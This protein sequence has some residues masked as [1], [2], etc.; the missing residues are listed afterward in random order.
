LT[1][2]L[3]R[4]IAT[5]A[6][7]HKHRPALPADYEGNLQQLPGGNAFLGWGQQ[8]YFAEFDARGRLVLDARFIPATANYRAYRHPWSATP[9]TPPAV[10]LSRSGPN[11][12]TPVERCH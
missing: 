2:D 6:G 8:P 5:R 1:L 10:T 9:S 4:T 11:V 12:I 3:Q 7:E